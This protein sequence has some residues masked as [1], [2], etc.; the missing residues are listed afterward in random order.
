MD[1]KSKDAFNGLSTQ[2]W[3]KNSRSVWNDLSSPRSKN[4]LKHG[5]TFPQKLSDRVISLYSTKG[6]IVLDPFLGTGTSARSALS[7]ERDF[8]GF[9]LN[10]E[11]YEVALTSLRQD[12]SLFDKNKYNIKQGD[13]LELVEELENN[14]LQLT[15][16]SPPYADLIHKVVDD[17]TKRHKKSAFVI[18]NNAT[19][20][21]YSRDTRDFGNMDFD[22][23]MNAVLQFMQKLYTKTKSNG[24]NVWVVKDYRDTR[25]KIPYVDLHSNI[26]NAGVKAGFKYHDLIIWDQNERRRLVLL[27]YPSVFYVNQNHSFI[28]VL[29]KP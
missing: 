16:T 24:Y 1:K 25:N 13:C 9:E 20:K 28:V 27:G 18:D 8:I 4:A 14:S 17:R 23:Y 3:A 21:I 11:F 26:A 5:A 19:T 12:S 15:I 7:L 2:E 22:S 29:R 10:M 6:D